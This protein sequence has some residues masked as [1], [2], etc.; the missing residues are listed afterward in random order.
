MKGAWLQCENAPS[1]LEC[2]CVLRAWW[3][4]Q[5]EKQ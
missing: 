1:Q 2:M 5:P 3:A 4:A